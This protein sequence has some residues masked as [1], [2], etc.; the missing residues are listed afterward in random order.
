M[1]LFD[2]ILID[3]SITERESALQEALRAVNTRGS[4]VGMYFRPDGEEALAAL[5]H[6]EGELTWSNFPERGPLPEDIR[7]VHLVWWTDFIGRR[8]YRAI[9]QSHHTRSLRMETR[10]EPH[11]W[12]QTIPLLQIYP[13][14]GFEACRGTEWQDTRVVCPCGAAGTPDQIGWMGTECGPCHDRREEGTLPARPW[15]WAGQELPVRALGLALH[16]TRPLLAVLTEHSMALHDCETNESRPIP[17]MLGTGM[18]WTPDGAGLLCGSD[19]STIHLWSLDGQTK[20]LPF[21][22]D[23]FQFSPSGRWLVL[24][25]SRTGT[26]RDLGAWDWAKQQ[27]APVRIQGDFLQWAFSPDELRMFTTELTGE[28]TEYN[29][30]SGTSRELSLLPINSIPPSS[31]HVTADG[32]ALVINWGATFTLMDITTGQTRLEQT[33]QDFNP[34][35][36]VVRLPDRQTLVGFN[37]ARQQMNFLSLPSLA[38][39]VRLAWYG[40]APQIVTSN[41]RWLAVGGRMGVRFLPWQPLLDWYASC[42]A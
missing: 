7:A 40:V 15:E 30:E 25:H 33:I 17:G 19:E 28:V 22:A 6:P 27:P 35:S 26:S 2:R 10:A 20:L 23:E 34:G 21:R 4:F 18:A 8:H 3:P 36:I 9:G 41:R 32:A 37:R 14:T 5:A 39:H 11:D 29:L 16:P 31:L 13:E 42:P 38:R 24:L 12:P 1:I